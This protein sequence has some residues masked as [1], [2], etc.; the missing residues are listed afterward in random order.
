MLELLPAERTAELLLECMLELLL[1][2]RI[3]AGLLERLADGAVER[4]AVLLLRV[5]V[6]TVLLVRVD[7]ERVAVDTLLLREALVPRLTDV[8][9]V[10]V[11]RVAVLSPRPLAVRTLLLPKVRDAVPALRVETRV[12]DAPLSIPTREALRTAVWR[13]RSKLRALL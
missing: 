10:A 12:A 1:L 8:A 13:L 11:P 2:E 5:G 9:R 4:T 3:V 7:A 6:A